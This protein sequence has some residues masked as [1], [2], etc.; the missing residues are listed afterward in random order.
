[1][2]SHPYNK[3]EAPMDLRKGET[4]KKGASFL[5]KSHQKFILVVFSSF[6]TKLLKSEWFQIPQIQK[7]YSQ[8]RLSPMNPI[9]YIDPDKTTKNPVVKYSRSD[10]TEKRIENK[11]LSK[12]E[13]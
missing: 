4:R 9:T 8:I 3:A 10:S 5:T 12:T 13:V 11:K 2:S 1:M 7:G 6:L